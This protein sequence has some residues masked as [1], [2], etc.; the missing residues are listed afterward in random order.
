VGDSRAIRSGS[1][2]AGDLRRALA[3]VLV[4]VLVV[5]GGT[6]LAWQRFT[7]WFDDSGD[8]RVDS[9]VLTRNERRV[10]LSRLQSV[11]VVQPLLARLVGLAELVI[12]VAGPGESR[13]RIA[14]LTEDHARSLRA[15]ILARAAGVHEA[16]GEAPEDVVHQVPSGLLLKA[17]LLR[18]TT[19]ALLLLSVLIVAG[20]VWSEGPA[21]GLLVVVTGGLPLI[22]VIA[23]FLRFADFTVARSPDGLRIRSGLLQKQSQTVPPGRVHAIGIVEPLLWRSFGWV[24]VVVTLASGPADD[25]TNGPTG[26]LLPVGTRDEAREIVARLL[27]GFEPEAAPWC[28]APQ[29]ARYRAPL[30]ARRLAYAVQEGSLWLRGGRLTHWTSW[31]PDAR[32]QSVS[33]VQGPWQ[34]RLRLATV[35]MDLVPGPVR[36]VLAH[37]DLDDARWLRE[38]QVPR[39]VAARASDLPARWM[40]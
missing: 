38:R 28:P 10:A 32:V 33:V 13:A 12:E 36:S 7:F 3:A 14:Y 30:Q 26:V 37:R 39:A 1:A 4:V 18:G 40:T 17:L 31:V 5:A 8:L 23:E 25:G 16:A 27:P 24:R 21:G 11:D 9:G 34:R 22:S 19:F 29:R 2:P 35:R 6:Y 20:A 15:E